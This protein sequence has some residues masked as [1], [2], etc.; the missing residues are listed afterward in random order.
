MLSRSWMNRTM[1]KTL[2]SSLKALP[3]GSILASSRN[4]LLR[5]KS[6]LGQRSMISIFSPPCLSFKSFF[7]ISLLSLACDSSES[8]KLLEI[9]ECIED[10]G[11]PKALI[12]DM[13]VPLAPSLGTPVHPFA[14]GDTQV[15]NPG[16]W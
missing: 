1:A 11:V 8:P 16:G 15:P 7:I 4:R 14:I 12:G 6:P 10:M 13:G 2:A 3:L 5:M 9:I